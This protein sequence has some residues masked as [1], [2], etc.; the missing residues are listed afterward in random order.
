MHTGK[1]IHHGLYVAANLGLVVGL[2]LLPFA[3]LGAWLGFAFWAVYSGYGSFPLLLILAG[4]GIWMLSFRW[5]VPIGAIQV[6]QSLERSRLGE[7][8]GGAL[9][10]RR[11]HR[12]HRRFPRP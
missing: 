2:L 3:A 1:C 6:K 11:V 4:L 9:G 10:H 8:G 12:P 5:G 7:R